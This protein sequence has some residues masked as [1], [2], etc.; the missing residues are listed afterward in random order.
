MYNRSC[1][2]KKAK[3]YSQTFYGLGFYIKIQ[4]FA[5]ALMWTVW[6]VQVYQKSDYF[7]G[8]TNFKEKDTEA[9]VKWQKAW[10]YNSHLNHSPGRN[11]WFIFGLLFR[12]VDFFFSKI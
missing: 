11:Q 1:S 7:N 3:L 10:S 12:L 4:M 5:S 6:E 8:F 2:K 9:N